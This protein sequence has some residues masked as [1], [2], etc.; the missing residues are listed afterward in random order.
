MADPAAPQ[1]L[2]DRLANLERD[3]R[4]LRAPSPLPGWTTFSTTL[5][6]SGVV[7]HNPLYCKYVKFGSLVTVAMQLTVTGGAGVANNNVT[8]SLPFAAAYASDLT[9]GIG[10]IYDWGSTVTYPGGVV[11]HTTTTAAMRPLHE[12]TGGYLGNSHFIQALAASDNVDMTFTY[13]A[14]V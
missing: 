2:L 6:Q 14:A 8:V 13:E 12:T 5:I 4:A 1:T 3:V 7:T 10:V 9:C 11:I